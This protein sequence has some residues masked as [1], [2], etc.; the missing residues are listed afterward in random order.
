MGTHVS[1]PLLLFF[2]FDILCLGS[3]SWQDVHALA[4]L[5]ENNSPRNPLPFVLLG[6]WFPLAELA[7]RCEWPWGLVAHRGRAVQL[8]PRM[9][10]GA[11]A[12]VTMHEASR[13]RKSRGA[14][15]ERLL[16]RTLPSGK[17]DWEGAAGRQSPKPSCWDRGWWVEI[18]ATLWLWMDWGIWQW[19][20]QTG[21]LLAS[22]RSAIYSVPIGLCCPILYLCRISQCLTRR[23]RSLS[24][25]LC[26]SEWLWW[27]LPTDSTTL[28]SLL[29]V[30]MS[31]G[32]TPDRSWHS[33][34]VAGF[35]SSA[36]L[37][38]WPA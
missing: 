27:P 30:C 11:I 14:G 28:L 4:F 5:T 23:L 21:A 19:P 12:S 13:S 34:K 38:L 25:D 31:G 1:V 2:P 26:C 33:S 37:S 9:T 20:W 10:L 8:C 6:S 7:G 17:H 15:W 24:S 22:K 36:L 18:N 16:R 35:S 32:D 29:P 3:C